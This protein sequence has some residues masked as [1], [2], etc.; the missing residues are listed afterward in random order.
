V[1]IPLPF[2]VTIS[3][4]ECRQWLLPSIGNK[5]HD[6][7]NS[8]QKEQSQSNGSGRCSGHALE[9]EGDSLNRK[10]LTRRILC[11]LVLIVSS[12]INGGGL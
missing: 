7:M 3:I 8:T 12:W 4:K 6:L 5:C 10:Q 9:K 2:F 11:D 1:E